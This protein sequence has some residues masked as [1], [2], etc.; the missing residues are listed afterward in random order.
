MNR[1]HSSYALGYPSCFLRTNSKRACYMWLWIVYQIIRTN[2]VL[3]SI[4]GWHFY[5]MIGFV[6]CN[7][8]KRVVILWD[9]PTNLFERN[10]QKPNG[11][12]SFISWNQQKSNGYPKMLL[13][14]WAYVW[15]YHILEDQVT[16]LVCSTVQTNYYIHNMGNTV[17]T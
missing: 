11:T 13:H 15:G 6:S 12:S 3:I 9:F 17:H 14:I 5:W 8:S 1:L 16:A 10:Y 2:Q 7:W 4:K